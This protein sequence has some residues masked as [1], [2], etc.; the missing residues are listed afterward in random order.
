V[1][2]GYVADLEVGDVLPPMDFA[3]TP[4]YVREYLHGCDF[5]SG[6]W[7]AIGDGRKPLAPPTLAHIAKLRLFG[8]SCPK[9]PANGVSRAKS[10]EDLARLHYE[11]FSESLAPI[12]AE[13]NLIASGEVLERYEKRGR[14]YLAVQVILRRRTDGA[15][16]VRYTDTAV[17]GY[18]AKGDTGA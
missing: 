5:D 7:S 8:A 15:I 4:F 16:V 14:E 1:I 10:G 12:G 11:Y 18:R 3:V 2:G 6:H 13:D 9:T 17:L